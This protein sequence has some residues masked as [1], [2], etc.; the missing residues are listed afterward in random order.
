METPVG[1][2]ATSIDC[3]VST[4]VT[5]APSVRAA[6][7]KLAEMAVALTLPPVIASERVVV[8]IAD[9][10]AKGGGVNGGGGVGLGGE[11]GGGDGVGRDGGLGARGL[12]G[13]GEWPSGS[14]GK[15]GGIKGTSSNGD[16][17]GF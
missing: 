17:R 14:S 4:T 3:D 12:Q 16:G 10:G 2:V 5:L 15:E 7:A 13:S 6:E 11:G 8:I 1:T 9:R